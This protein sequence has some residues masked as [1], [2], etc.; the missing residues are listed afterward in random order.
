M[1][2]DITEAG[3][4]RWSLVQALD[5]ADTQSRAQPTQASRLR[6]PTQAPTY[7]D[8]DDRSAIKLPT[9]CLLTTPPSSL[10]PPIQS[11]QY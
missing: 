4:V 1:P 9:P 10:A 6:P 8:Q 2:W 7:Q 11:K 5:T 3:R